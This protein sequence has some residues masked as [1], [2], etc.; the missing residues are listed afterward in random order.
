MVL[1]DAKDLT[2]FLKLRLR[3]NYQLSAFVMK[4]DLGNIQSLL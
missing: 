3:I 2:D 4:Q 1:F